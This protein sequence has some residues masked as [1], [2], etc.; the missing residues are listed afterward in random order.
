M[1]HGVLLPKLHGLRAEDHRPRSYAGLSAELAGEG[2][3]RGWRG[4]D[5]P[6][7]TG[8]PED[9]IPG[10]A[11][12]ALPSAWSHIA[13]PRATAPG[14]TAHPPLSGAAHLSTQIRFV[15]FTDTSGVDGTRLSHTQITAQCQDPP[16]P[17]LHPS[18]APGNRFYFRRPGW[19]YDNIP[20]AARCSWHWT[21]RV[22]CAAPHGAAPP[23]P[24]RLSRLH[25]LGGRRGRPHPSPTRTTTGSPPFSITS[26]PQ[27]TTYS[28]VPPTPDQPLHRQ[29]LAPAPEPI[30][31]PEGPTPAHQPRAP[32]PRGTG[33]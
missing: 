18:C 11:G 9:A 21:R 19:C 29:S 33:L 17:L 10:L 2:R 3:Q 7:C 23:A 15:I 20:R 12:D 24:P 27:P 14:A 26:P 1:L 4:Q 16:P 31:H 25:P 28:A 32:R 22:P 6:G 13:A 5:P 30:L 8:S